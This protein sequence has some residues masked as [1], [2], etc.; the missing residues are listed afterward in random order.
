MGESAIETRGPPV[1]R[2]AGPILTM[3]EACLYFCFFLAW[4]SV[5]EGKELLVTTDGDLSGLGTRLEQKLINY[6]R[7]YIRKRKKHA[8]R[9][10]KILAVL[11]GC[12]AT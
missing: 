11:L 1:E 2:K 4:A 9:Q 6:G 8:D 3:K 7:G 5:G 12:G 10:L